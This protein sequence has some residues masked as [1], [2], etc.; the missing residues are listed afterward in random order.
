MGENSRSLGGQL[1]AS[2]QADCGAVPSPSTSRKKSAGPSLNGSRAAV[3]LEI[4]RPWLE[5]GVEAIARMATNTREA[6]WLCRRL[7]F[8]VKTLRHDVRQTSETEVLNYLDWQAGRGQ[9]DWQVLQSLS[10]ICYMLEFGCE[11]K[12]FQFPVL[13]ERW[14]ERRGQSAGAGSDVAAGTL[15][16]GLN[17]ATVEG[18]LAR[19]LRVLHYSRRTEQAY[20]Q[21]WRQFRTYCGQYPNVNKSWGWQYVFPAEG[22]STDPRSGAVRRHHLHESS[23]QKAFKLAVDRSAINKPASAHTLRHSFATHL[24]EDRHDT[25]TVQ[26]LLGHKDVSTTMIYTHVLNRPGLAVRSPLEGLLETR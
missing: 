13:R 3:G 16:F 4:N 23:F 14:L 15:D 10:A 19:R 21:W 7:E 22:F 25:R 1:V 6:E 26:E 17:V 9:K 8:F 24:L 5:K 18:R 20:T 11:M 2:S 12:E